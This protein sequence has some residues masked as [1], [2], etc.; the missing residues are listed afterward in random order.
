MDPSVTAT[1]QLERASSPQANTLFS[2][3]LSKLTTNTD[4]Y[5]FTYN[6]GFITGTALAVSLNNQRI[7]TDNPFV[8][9]SPQLSST[10]NAK[11][12]QHLLQGAGIFVNK[13]YVYQAINNRQITDLSLIHI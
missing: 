10:F 2:G 4:Q 13:R 11:V 3:G 7:T 6:Q 5:N 8:D 12:T 1:V 9:Y